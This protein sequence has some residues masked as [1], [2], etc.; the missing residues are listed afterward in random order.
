MIK[1]THPS[2]ICKLIQTHIWDER[3]VPEFFRDSV[4][5]RECPLDML[6]RNLAALG[7]QLGNGVFSLSDKVTEPTCFDFATLC[8]S[9]VDLV[10]E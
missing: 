10:G 3:M 9:G 7:A 2:L 4:R 5:L 1:Q 8:T 6:R